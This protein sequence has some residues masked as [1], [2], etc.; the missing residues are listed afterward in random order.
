MDPDYQQGLEDDDQDTPNSNGG[1]S[2]RGPTSLS[3]E[4]TRC[5][6]TTWGTAATT[7]PTSTS[8]PTATSTSTDEDRPP[9]AIPARTCA[10]TAMR[11]PGPAPAQPRPAARASCVRPT[12]DG[13]PPDSVGSSTVQ[14]T[15]PPRVGAGMHG[16]RD[17]HAT[18]P[19]GDRPGMG[20]HKRQQTFTGK[21]HRPS[22]T[23]DTHHPAPSP[24]TMP[25]TPSA[26]D[27]RHPLP[28][29]AHHDH[30]TRQDNAAGQAAD[31]AR[32]CADPVGRHG[33]SRT[34]RSRGTSHSSKS[35]TCVSP[36]A[37]RARS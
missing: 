2:R 9:A 16:G 29:V 1:H 6:A 19:N 17:P 24:R 3:S 31:E 36:S 22:P 32:L 7:S 8:R 26:K 30:T 28:H 23:D 10:A 18:N 20:L 37:R 34:F 15:G 13:R 21:R 12:R 25:L 14:N 11:R 4:A 5:P 27:R 35:G 33:T